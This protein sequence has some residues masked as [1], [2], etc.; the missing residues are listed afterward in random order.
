MG[1]PPLFAYILYCIT[2]FSNC[3]TAFD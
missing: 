1:I 2:L 3:T